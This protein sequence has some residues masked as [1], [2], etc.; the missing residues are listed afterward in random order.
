MRKLGSVSGKEDQAFKI[1]RDEG[2]FLRAAPA[3][4]PAFRSN[5]VNNPIKSL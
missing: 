2:L 1:A 4:E 5:R 3:L